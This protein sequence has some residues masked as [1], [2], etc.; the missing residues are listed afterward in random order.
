MQKVSLSLFFV[1]QF[2]IPCLLLPNRMAGN[3]ITWLSLVRSSPGLHQYSR[4]LCDQCLGIVGVGVEGPVG[5]QPTVL[6]G[7][8]WKAHGPLFPGSIGSRDSLLGLCPMKGKWSFL[9]PSKGLC[10]W[11]PYKSFSGIWTFPVEYHQERVHLQPLSPS[12]AP[13]SLEKIASLGKINN[14]LWLHWIPLLPLSSLDWVLLK[15]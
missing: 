10:A 9:R 8:S 12:S 7:F 1:T 3:W 11:S 6:T 2:L 4:I 5:H 13:I 15:D 14:L